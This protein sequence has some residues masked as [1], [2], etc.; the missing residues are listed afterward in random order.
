[1]NNNL[2]N[3]LLADVV[4][5]DKSFVLAEEALRGLCNEGKLIRGA[6]GRTEFAKNIH[7]LRHYVAKINLYFSPVDVFVPAGDGFHLST[8]YNNIF[9]LEVIGPC[10][11]VHVQMP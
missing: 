8:Y 7:L 3:Y 11:S 5:T 1:M 9:I 6:I 4:I 2:V 10:Y